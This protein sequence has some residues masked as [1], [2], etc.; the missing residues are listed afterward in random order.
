MT[1]RPDRVPF[2]SEDRSFPYVLM[3]ST[4]GTIVSLVGVWIITALSFAP[5]ASA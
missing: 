3:Y 2:F 1:T 5:V 4:L